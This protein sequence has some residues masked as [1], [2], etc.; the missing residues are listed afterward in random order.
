MED[1]G[2]IEKAA[3]KFGSQAIVV[4]INSYST[5]MGNFITNAY[6]TELC[7]LTPKAM[8][9]EAQNLGAGE[10]LLTDVQKDGTM[11]GYNCDLIFECSY[12]LSIPVIANGGCGEA[13]HMA[14][15]LRSGASAVAAGSMFLYTEATPKRCAKYLHEEK[16]NVRL[17]G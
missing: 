1:P 10:I 9:H 4:A 12:D 6:Y 15:A 8:C 7:D 14:H 16:F 2:F 13:S 3:R 11:K 5:P 17:H